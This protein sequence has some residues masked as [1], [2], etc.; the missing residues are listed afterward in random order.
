MA[1]TAHELLAEVAAEGEDLETG[2][3]ACSRG[4]QS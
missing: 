4:W 3:E 1:Q 2:P